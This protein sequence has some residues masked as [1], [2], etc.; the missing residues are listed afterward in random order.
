M[1]RKNIFPLL[2]LFVLALFV[3]TGCKKEKEVAPTTEKYIGVWKLD[4]YNY[5]VVAGNIVTPFYTTTGSTQ[6]L[7]FRT[8]G[9]IVDKDDSGQETLGSWTLTP[10]TITVTFPAEATTGEI[11]SGTY[12]VK[13]IT[14][15]Q[16]V[17]F[18]RKVTTVLGISGGNETTITYKR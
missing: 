9:K 11:K 17:L 15:T 1:Q 13:Q 18:Q 7:E 4:T 16:L 3:F 10:N 14:D 12:E 8:D 6:S 5:S 2:S